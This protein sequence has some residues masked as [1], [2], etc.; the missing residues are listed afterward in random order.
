MEKDEKQGKV[1][2]FNI[3]DKVLNAKI[4][5]YI[6]RTECGEIELPSWPDFCN[7]L[8]CP[9]DTLDQVMQQG[10]AL[11]GAYYDR[12]LA[13][14]RMAAWCEAQLVSNPRWGGKMLTKS[15]FLLKQ[16]FGGTRKYIDEKAPAKVIPERLIID[17]GGDKRAKEA[18]K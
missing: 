13:L 7:F 15:I 4:D 17:M 3:S 8:G 10:F 14:K 2:N 9:A 5:E 18:G 11:R 1:L 12:A 6:K 16:G